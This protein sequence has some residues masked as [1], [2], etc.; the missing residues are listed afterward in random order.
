MILV[1]SYTESFYFR[2]N[3]HF[4]SW[5][6][7]Y[8]FLLQ[9]QSEIPKRKRNLADDPTVVSISILGSPATQQGY[10]FVSR[11]K[12][13][14][15]NLP[16][17]PRSTRGISTFPNP[18]GSLGEEKINVKIFLIFAYIGKPSDDLMINVIFCCWYV[19]LHGETICEDSTNIRYLQV[20]ELN[21]GDQVGGAENNHNLEH[22][23]LQ[24]NISFYRA[25]GVAGKHI[26]FY[27]A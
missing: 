24:V 6:Q 26:S 20:G 23:V 1:S 5:A 12:N 3:S 19:C 10:K 16:K 14:F 9:D 22:R 7:H 13:Y 15:E 4:T 21:L 2:C 8:T 11:G 27:R 25:Q 18:G 17:I